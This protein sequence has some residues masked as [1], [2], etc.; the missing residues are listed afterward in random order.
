METDEFLER[1]AFVGLVIEE[2]V[3][4]QIRTIVERIG[5]GQVGCGV[6]PECHEWI[7]TFDPSIS[8]VADAVSS[9]HHTGLVGIRSDHDEADT[10]MIDQAG[11][12]T[13]VSFL[14]VGHAGSV[15]DESERHQTQ[16]ARCEDDDVFVT[17]RLVLVPAWPDVDIP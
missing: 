6:R 1:G 8:K 7:D 16:V 4:D 14:D 17:G 13:R 12:Q 15:F 5:A 2:A 9:E 3:D 11:D 10:R